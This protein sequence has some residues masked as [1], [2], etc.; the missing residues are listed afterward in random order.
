MEHV[1][2]STKWNQKLPSHESNSGWIWKV[3]IVNSTVNWLYDIV[4]S[5]IAELI[6]G[7]YDSCMILT[8]PS[9]KCETSTRW[10][11]VSSA[12]LFCLVV[13]PRVT[14]EMNHSAASRPAIRYDHSITGSYWPWRVEN[15]HIGGTH[16][17]HEPLPN[18][19]PCNKSEISCP[20]ISQ[21]RHKL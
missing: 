3:S 18:Q 17:P 15:N 10:L 8:T 13:F 5:S 2:G 1:A 16:F 20:L 9:L 14:N 4:I 19:A 6:A 11:R 12:Q 7:K 21:L